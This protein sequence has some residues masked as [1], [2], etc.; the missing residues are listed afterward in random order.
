MMIETA[1]SDR[2]VRGRQEAPLVREGARPVPT[3]EPL[4][5]DLSNELDQL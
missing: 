5:D 3:V 1:A 2:A 4:F